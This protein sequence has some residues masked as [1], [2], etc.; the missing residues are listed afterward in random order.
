MF[1]LAGL[2][3][4]TAVKYDHSSLIKMFYISL[5]RP[6]EQANGNFIYET[7]IEGTD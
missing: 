2:A 1:R 3:Y 4:K 5:S 6:N 7:L